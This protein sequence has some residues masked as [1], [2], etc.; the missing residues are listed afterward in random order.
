MTIG[1]F[2]PFVNLFLYPRLRFIRTTVSAAQKKK[3]PMLHGVFILGNDC[4][5]SNYSLR[6]L[7][8]DRFF[9]DLLFSVVTSLRAAGGTATAPL[10]M[11]C[12]ASSF[13]PYTRSLAS[14]SGRT[15]EP[16]REIPAKRPRARE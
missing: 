4:C 13:L 5:L 12:S 8:S 11:I 2:M 14:L 1:H 9:G 10:K 15:V 16:S 7:G 6:E 3:T